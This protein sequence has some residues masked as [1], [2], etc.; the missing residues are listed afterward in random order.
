[1]EQT[2][3]AVEPKKLPKVDRVLAAPV[4]AGA[5]TALG[6]RTLTAIVRDV[7]ASHRRRV[8]SGETAPSE[9]AVIEEV[10]RAA[11]RRRAAG[12]VRVIN[13]TGVL[14]HTNLGRAPLPQASLDRIAETAGGY[15]NVELDLELGTRA[16]RGAAVEATLAELV[17]AEDA[18]VVNNNAAAV[19]LALSGLAAGR[20]VIVSRGELVEIGGGFR[21]PEVLARSGARLVEVGTTN[22]TRASDYEK[23]IGEHTACILCVH[24]SNFRISG[25]TER[26]SLAALSRVAR[27]H[28]VVLVDDLGGGL[29]VELPRQTLLGSG[30]EGEPTVQSRIAAG[31]DLVCFSLDK[32]FGGPQG[33]VIAGSRELV[34]KLREDPLA[35]A[36]RV[37]KLGFAAL[38]PVVAAYARGELETIPVHALLATP[39]EALLERVERWRR[40]LGPV[41]AKRSEAVRVEGAVGGGTLAEA[42]VDSAALS[43]RVDD[44]DALAR[45][46]R[47]GS[48]PVVARI[49]EDRLL[50]DA[51]SV[52]PAE[53]ADL[54]ASLKA[55]LEGLVDSV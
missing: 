26:P 44:V 12:L 35:R 52:F 32:L 11:D 13:A 39:V 2:R 46:L 24:P 45:R 20:E 47:A 16:R 15:S 51:R 42:P 38:E 8:R 55:A 3:A 22:R 1:M 50:L 49:R 23:A 9:A 31:A 27:A 21:I 53:D 36:L 4:L 34:G 6:A 19:L 10:A 7:I 14:L 18:L 43:I 29:M 5:R 40:D 17:G 37:D 54:V 28:G 30:L 48:P 41:L 33:G 25:F